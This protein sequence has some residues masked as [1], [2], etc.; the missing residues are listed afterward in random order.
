M[1]QVAVRA[2]GG[3][4]GGVSRA[5]VVCE[6]PA[7][8]RDRLLQLAVC[9][10][11]GDNLHAAGQPRRIAARSGY[12]IHHLMLEAASAPTSDAAE[13]V[14]AL[15]DE[16]P[17]GG[18]GTDAAPEAAE[19]AADLQVADPPAADAAAS[20]PAAAPAVEVS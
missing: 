19:A 6:L 1:D 7:D 15:A 2:I 12:W 17:M 11:D 18:N 8:D 20:S 4:A 9:P 16:T 5:A 3:A 13:A 10:S 14:P